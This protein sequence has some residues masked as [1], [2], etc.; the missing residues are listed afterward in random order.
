MTDSTGFEIHL[1]HA[2]EH[3]VVQEIVRKHL[4]IL[5]AALFDEGVVDP[6]IE[7]GPYYIDS[8]GRPTK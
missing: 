1:T 8:Y 6:A 4:D 5:M 7:M 3:D 2:G